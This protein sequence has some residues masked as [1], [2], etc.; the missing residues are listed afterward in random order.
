[1]IL[2]AVQHTYPESGF[3][4]D[5][6]EIDCQ[7]STIGLIGP[8]GSGKST[9]ARQ[10]AA[11]AESDWFYLPQYPEDFLFAENLEEQLSE[12]LD[13][14]MDMY[15]VRQ[16]LL[17]LGLDRVEELVTLPFHFL[18][19]GELRRVALACAFYVQP[20]AIILD[21]PGIGLGLKE[22]MVIIEKINKLASV[23]TRLLVI[24]HDLDILE[25]TSSVL[26][27]EEGH[28]VYSGVRDQFLATEPV[29]FEKCGIR[30]HGST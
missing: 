9:Y 25:A 26:V 22:K 6:P 17:E 14:K 18:S 12:L 15:Q 24:T 3:A 5:L 1:M 13:R 30:V 29:L 4:V 8:N 10:L 19:S 11:G 27:L 20:A 16:T 21:E 7:S 28:L 23:N 2:P